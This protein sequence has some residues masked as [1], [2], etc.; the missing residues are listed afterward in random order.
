MMASTFA[1]FDQPVS[2]Q[3]IVAA[4]AEGTLLAMPM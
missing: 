4:A 3:D 2:I 1:F